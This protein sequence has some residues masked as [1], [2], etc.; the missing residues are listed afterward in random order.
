MNDA[1]AIGI[2]TVS[3]LVAA[4][5]QLILKFAAL[6]PNGKEG[7]MRYMDIRIVISYA[8]LFATVFMNMIA[9]RYMPYKFAPVLS[10]VSYVF[11]LILGRF[12]LHERIGGK[13]ALGIVIIFLGMFV[14]YIG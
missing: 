6:K 5:S 11:V 14:F 9:M 12:V 1:I 3:G 8:M 4:I 2:Y 13:K 10:S 7:I